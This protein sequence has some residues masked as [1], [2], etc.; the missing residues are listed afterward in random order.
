MNRGKGSGVESDVES[1]DVSKEPLGRRNGGGDERKAK[2]AEEATD[3]V[4]A[5]VPGTGW[6]HSAEDGR[7]QPDSF[8]AETEEGSSNRRLVAL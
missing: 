2:A 8:P 6:G 4:L 5:D 1:R 7:Q 3:V